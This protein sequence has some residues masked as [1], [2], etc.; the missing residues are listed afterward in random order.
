MLSIF[1]A[2]YTKV[3]YKAHNY[4]VPCDILVR[5]AVKSKHDKQQIF[6]QLFQISK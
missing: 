1:T 3:I 2:M 5:F 4:C 6:K